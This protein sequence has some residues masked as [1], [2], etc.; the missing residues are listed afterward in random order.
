LDGSSIVLAAT[1][2]EVFGSYLLG[3]RVASA[4][5][6]RPK[7]P[8]SWQAGTQRKVSASHAMAA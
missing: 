1:A 2:L 3:K 4:S 5:V 6:W 7:I 8:D